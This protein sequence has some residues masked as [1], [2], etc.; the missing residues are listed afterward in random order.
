ME[1]DLDLYRRDVLL[2]AEPRVRLSVIE[3]GPP[4]AGETLV[5]VH[6]FG[7]QAL[8]WANQLRYFASDH[9]CIAFDLRGHGLS[10]APPTGYGLDRLLGDLE[11][12]LHLLRVPQP[13]T[14]VAHSFGGAIAASYAV[15]HPEAVRKLVLTCAPADYRLPWAIRQVFQAP[16]AALNAVRRRL[17]FYAPAHVLKRLY[18]ETL[19]TWPGAAL[20]PNIQAPTLVII[21]QRD[22]AY[23]PTRYRATARLIPHAQ[24][25]TI[26]TSAHLVQLERPDAVNRA[27]Q[28][29]LGARPVS[30]REFGRATAKADRPWTRFYDAGVPYEVRPPAQPLDRFLTSAARRR[31]H[32]PALVFYGRRLTY[33]EL[34][35][36]ANRLANALL[37]AGLQRGDRVLVMLPNCPQAAIACYGV[38]RAGGVLVMA[39]PLATAAEL[40]H[41]VRDSDPRHAI[42]LAELVERLAQAAVGTGLRRV[43]LTTLGHLPL[44]ARL[45][46]VRGA[47]RGPAPAGAGPDGLRVD[48]MDALLASASDQ[49]PEVA[50]GPED[51]ACLQYTSGTTAEP[52]GV[53]LTHANLVANTVQARSWL[54]DVRFGAEVY[55]GVLPLWHIYGLMSALSVPVSLAATVVLLPRFEVMETLRAIRRY[56]PTLFPG[57]P[58]MFMAIKDAPDVRRYGVASIRACLSGA[59]PLPVEVQEAFEK[60]TRGRLVEGYGLTEAG[61][62]THVNPLG[63][64]RRVGSIGLPLPSTDAKVVD[65]RTGL[66]VPAG[67][68]GELCVRG[69]QVMRGYWNRPAET[70]LAWRDGWLHTGDVARMDEDGFFQIIERKADVWEAATPDGTIVFPRDVEEILYEHPKVSEVAVTPIH[71]DAAS[72]LKAFIVLRRHEQAT[73]AEI[74]D[75]VRERLPSSALP[76]WVEFVEDLPRSPIGKV[77]RRLLAP[78]TVGE[79]RG[80]DEPVAE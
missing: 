72:G 44:G 2:S 11:S 75:Y 63:G 10:D 20:L 76:A 77:I 73:A 64:R 60:V 69:P 50:V 66:D 14:L 15:A 56:H 33:D 62:V 3:V 30:W 45:S 46:R 55:L 28:R 32:R 38:L 79:L 78:P 42:A 4:D 59:A 53:M 1:L 49:P 5:F 13:I 57:V 24:T 36:A 31:P 61:P 67:A 9:R 80:H 34:D 51:L 21:G 70:A 47:Q 74:L 27:L 8:Q 39:S 48:E 17:R 71:T 54:P 40:A 58:S 16:D 12:T 65:L 43:T 22:L 52:K 68:I 7:G 37:A 35:R 25:V 18:A 23:P 6:G 29:F 26:P 41:Q 19:H